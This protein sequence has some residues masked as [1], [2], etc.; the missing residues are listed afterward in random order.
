MGIADDKL[1]KFFVDAITGILN[2]FNKL[3]EGID[4]LGGSVVRVI[5][6]FSGF[7]AVGLILDKAVGHFVKMTKGQETLGLIE[8]L[9]RSINNF[10]LGKG[11]NVEGKGGLGSRIEGLGKKLT[12]LKG[13]TVGLGSALYNA[14]AP[15]LPLIVSI[16]AA[17]GL[18][19]AAWYFSDEQVLA[20]ELKAAEDAA[21]SAGKMLEEV[22]S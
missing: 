9:T 19:T 11:F 10:K 7:K 15:L 22:N 2:T 21:S 14:L 18:M 16:T 17:I 13:S 20:R 1:V 6:A 4:G 12:N 5:A 8:T 3:T